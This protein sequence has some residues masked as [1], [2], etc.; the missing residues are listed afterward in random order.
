MFQEVWKDIIGFKG[1]YQISNLG[2]LKSLKRSILRNDGSYMNLRERILKPKIDKYGY[3]TYSLTKGNLSKHL[4][5]HR[6]VAYA[7]LNKVEGASQINHI[8]GNK[9]NNKPENIEWCNSCHNNREAV[10]LGLRGGKPYKV[11]V[12]SRPI[13]QFKDGILVKRHQSLAFACRYANLKKTSISN[14]LQGRSKSSGGY[15]WKFE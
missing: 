1:Y 9:M 5:A 11:R 4:T 2:R 3:I 7:F 8:D 14:C 13:L 10:R 6:L 15:V 12:D